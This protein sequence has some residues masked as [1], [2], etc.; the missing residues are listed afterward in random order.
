VVGRLAA[1]KGV[2][3]AVAALARLVAAGLPVELRVVGAAMPADRDLPARVEAQARALGVADRVRL[4]GE[5]ADVPELMPG[6]ALLLHPTRAPEPFGR[7]VVEAMAAS[8]PVV[9][10]AHGGPREIVVPGET[11]LLVPPGDPDALAAAAEEL[12]RDPERAARLGRAGRVR[13]LERFDIAANAR[14]VM[15]AW[16]EVLAGRPQKGKTG[17]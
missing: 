2:E 6:F 5:R 9:A 7:V 11:G 17:L 1:W 13:A 4:L 15:A 8:V 14:A 16:D 3:D 10:A 12:L